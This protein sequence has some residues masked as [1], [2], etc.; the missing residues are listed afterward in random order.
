[1]TQHIHQLCLRLPP[2]C[3]A[4][5]EAEVTI[6]TE[7]S[8]PSNIMEKNSWD[9]SFQAQNTSLWWR[10]TFQKVQEQVTT[11]KSTG[12]R[13]K[14]VWQLSKRKTSA[15]Y[16]F[17]VF[18]YF[19][20]MNRLFKMRA[21]VAAICYTRTIKCTC[22]NL[23]YSC[24]VWQLWGCLFS[25]SLKYLLNPNWINSIFLQSEIRTENKTI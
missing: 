13:N 9:W 4:K 3:F 12:R 8:V 24:W 23:S 11:L 7:A 15:F 22:I 14:Y 5:E 1:M 19:V 16:I 2:S 18:F 10:K 25:V 6:Q 21:T 17:K 20:Y